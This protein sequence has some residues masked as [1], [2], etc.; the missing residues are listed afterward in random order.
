MAKGGAPQ[1]QKRPSPDFLSALPVQF[2]DLLPVRY[3]QF[4]ARNVAIKAQIPFTYADA[5]PWLDAE[6][7]VR[8]QCVLWWRRKAAQDA[9][10]RASLDRNLQLHPEWDRVLHPEKYESD[11][12]PVK[13][14]Q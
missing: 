4:V 5:E 6:P 7:T 12:S 3:P 1:V 14:N 10:F 13:V 9:A 11:E 2:R 8:R